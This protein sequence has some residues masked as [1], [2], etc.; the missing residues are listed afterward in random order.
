MELNPTGA[1][2]RNRPVV[3]PKK[4]MPLMQ[5]VKIDDKWP[6]VPCQKNYFESP[7]YRHNLL[8]HFGKFS[9][10]A[11][12]GI[13]G[14]EKAMSNFYQDEPGRDPLY[15]QGFLWEKL[16]ERVFSSQSFLQYCQDET[17]FTP[18]WNAATQ[19]TEWTGT[20]TPHE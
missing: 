4:P 18:R 12:E 1:P 8:H 17:P 20:H 5:Q 10:T 9:T 7:E 16:L 13:S 3:P 15:L 14:E 2:I 19:K 11:T 6:F